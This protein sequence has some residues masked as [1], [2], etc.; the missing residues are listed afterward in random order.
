MPNAINT[1]KDTPSML[2]N[3]IYFALRL[4][5]T[6]I[7]SS[8]LQQDCKKKSICLIKPRYP[9]SRPSPLVFPHSF[10]AYLLWISLNF[11]FWFSLSPTPTPLPP[12]FFFLFFLRSPSTQAALPFPQPTPPIHLRFTTP[13]DRTIITNTASALLPL[14]EHIPNPLFSP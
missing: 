10:R 11:F 4:Q 3:V 7:Y 1:K 9:F 12:L 13:S 6:A 14:S 8:P 2:L 5:W